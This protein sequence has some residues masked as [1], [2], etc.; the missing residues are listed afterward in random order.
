MLLPHASYVFTTPSLSFNAK[1]YP[2]LAN[3]FDFHILY[4]LCIASESPQRNP[5]TTQMRDSN[6]PTN[7]PTSQVSNRQYRVPVPLTCPTTS[8]SSRS[9]SRR[10]LYTLSF[11]VSPPPVSFVLPF[12]STII[13]QHHH[14]Q[15]PP[16]AHASLLPVH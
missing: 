7:Q 8:S 4:T 15:D 12:G 10:A 13:S 3:G 16:F 1:V 6:Q 11:I 9:N 5:H 14:P 2:T